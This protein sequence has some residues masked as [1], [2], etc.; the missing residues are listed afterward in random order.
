LKQIDSVISG[1]EG[2][3]PSEY[4]RTLLHLFGPKIALAGLLLFSPFK[5]MF[6]HSLSRGDRQCQFK[7]A[8][9]MT[10]R[11]TG[12]LACSPETDMSLNDI[13]QRMGCSHSVVASINRKYEVRDYQ[14]RR[15]R[16]TLTTEG[17]WSKAS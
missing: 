2:R 3:S 17:A 10:F 13:A 16:W 7:D 14:G 6:T 8:R 12:L 15:N 5:F 1:D 11:F 4:L 9:W